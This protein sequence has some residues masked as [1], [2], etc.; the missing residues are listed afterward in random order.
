MSAMSKEEC[1]NAR[2]DESLI[3]WFKK[4]A[5]VAGLFG[6]LIPTV[7]G[8]VAIYFTVW[9]DIDNNTDRSVATAALVQEMKES[10]RELEKWQ[11]Q[12]ENEKGFDALDGQ[13]LEART[14]AANT[15]LKD[16]LSKE[17]NALKAQQAVLIA[18]QKQNNDLL[19]KID[20]RI[21]KLR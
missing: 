14:V 21:D 15:A 12:R 9:R 19:H 18:M 7:A 17:I 1:G 6:S 11:V 2:P 8:G 3:S 13:A 5:V 10:I 4:I 20:D 16:E